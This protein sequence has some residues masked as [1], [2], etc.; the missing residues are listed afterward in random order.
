MSRS[1]VTRTALTLFTLASL[2]LTPLFAV[3]AFAQE[4]LVQRRDAFRDW[5]VFVDE[6]GARKVCFAATVP[7]ESEAR[8]GGRVVNVRR[9]PIYLVVSSFPAENVTNEISVKLGYP[10]DT[11]KTPVIKIDD[12]SFKMFGDGEEIW[13]ESPDMDK[14]A[15]DAMKAGRGSTVTAISKRGTETTDKFS[16][17]GF[18]AAIDRMNEL[19][20]E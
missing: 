11:N 10:S 7:T 12:K 20:Q 15:V 5:A 9:G 14:Q 19:C 16:L 17:L 2:C 4:R 13:L 6:S 1:R 18:T 8:R 3:S